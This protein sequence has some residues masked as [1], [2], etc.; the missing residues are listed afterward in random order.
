MPFFHGT[1]GELAFFFAADD[2]RL[3]PKG[4]LD[5]GNH[6]VRVLG[7]AHS[8]GHHGGLKVCPQGMQVHAELRHDGFEFLDSLFGNGAVL[9]NVFAQAT[10]FNFLQLRHQHLL[11]RGHFGRLSV[12]S[13][14]G[15]SRRFGP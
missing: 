7:I 13:V 2:P 1:V 6:F 8:L 12:L 14:G 15:F 9:V 3:H 4:L 10:D 5:G 11:I